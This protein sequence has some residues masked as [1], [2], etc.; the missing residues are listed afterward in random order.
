[1]ERK[2]RGPRL[3]ETK[4]HT[5]AEQAK[6]AAG[7]QALPATNQ[8]GEQAVE[9]PAVKRYVPL[10]PVVAISGAGRN[11]R[12]GGD[13]RWSIDGNLGVRRPSQVAQD[14]SGLVRGADLL[15]SLGSGALPPEAVSLAREVLLLSPHLTSWL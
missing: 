12:L 8:P 3:A 4:G 6:G 5:G 14:Y 7:S 9:R 2:T 13:G 10:D 15:A 11:L 1:E